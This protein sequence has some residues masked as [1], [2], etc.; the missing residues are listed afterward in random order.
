MARYTGAELQIVP[1]RRSKAFPKRREMLYCTKCAVQRRNLC[2]GPAWPEPEEKSEVRL[3]LREKQK[4]RR[5]YGLFRRASSRNT[6]EK[7]VSK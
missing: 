7:A 2:S 5:L 4:A 3:Q 1:Q 6:F